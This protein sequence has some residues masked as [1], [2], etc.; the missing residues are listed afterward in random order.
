[1][2]SSDLPVRVFAGIA[3][4]HLLCHESVVE[5]CR[6]GLNDLLNLLI[7]IMDEIDLDELIY[8]LQGLIDA[9]EEEIAPYAVQLAKKLSEAFMRL[10]MSQDGSKESDDTEISLSLSGCMSAIVKVLSSLA[11]KQQHQHAY[12]QIEQLVLEPLQAG[13]SPQ[14]ESATETSLGC[15]AELLFN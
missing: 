3:L 1:M 8:S 10:F 12:P 13:L 2:K 4:V 11:Q 5:L 15:I 6:P 7:H 14:G 9:Y